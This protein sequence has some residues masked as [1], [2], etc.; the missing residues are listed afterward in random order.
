MCFSND[1]P[2]PAPPPAPP[3]P[4]PPTLEQTAPK[5][6]APK[7]SEQQARRASG[8]KKYRNPLAIEQADNQVGNTNLS[9]P[10]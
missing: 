10:L 2:D 9:I 3:P 7:V 1:K 8:T 6:A 5:V 4:P